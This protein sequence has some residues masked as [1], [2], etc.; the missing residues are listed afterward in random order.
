MRAGTYTLSF[1]LGGNT[2]GDAVEKTK[3]RIGDWSTAVTLPSS[4]PLTTYTYT[5]TTTGGHLWFRDFPAAGNQN[6]GNILDNVVLLIATSVPEL[7]R[8]P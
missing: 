6:V 8:G 2:Q 1:K 3:I 5:F 7:S 4:D